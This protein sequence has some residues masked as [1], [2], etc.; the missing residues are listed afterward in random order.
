MHGMNI[1]IHGKELLTD[2]RRHFSGG[3]NF[4]LVVLDDDKHVSSKSVM[5]LGT[6]FT[7]IFGNKSCFI[8][9]YIYCC[10]NLRISPLRYGR[11]SCKMK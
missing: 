6:V 2:W 5:G 1:K 4:K 3:K 8:D 9:S 7:S 11:N 10:T